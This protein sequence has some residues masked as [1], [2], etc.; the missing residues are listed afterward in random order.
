MPIQQ[1]HT[2]IPPNTDTVRP[3]GPTLIGVNITPLLKDMMG[4]WGTRDD[5]AT[6]TSSTHWQESVN[7]LTTPHTQADTLVEEVFYRITILFS[8]NKSL[9]FCGANQHRQ[10]R[11]FI[12]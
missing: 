2:K 7:L 10:K 12:T 4:T 11:T 3:C 6:Q 1:G 5:I 9:L 8:E